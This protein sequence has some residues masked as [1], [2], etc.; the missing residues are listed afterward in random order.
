MRKIKLILGAS[1]LL[2]ASV[3]ANA[4]LIVNGS[5]EDPT[6]VGPYEHRNGNELTGWT[7]FSTYKGT[8]Q[9]D[10]SY[11]A[12]S[13]GSQAVQIEVPGDWISQSF[14]T[15]IGQEYKV[16]FDLSAYPVYGG[17]NLGRATCAPFCVSVLGV[18]AGSA[19]GVFS[20]ISVAYL[21]HALLFDA[22]STTSTVK[23]KNLYDGDG[24]GNYPHLDNVSVE[25]VPA[26]AAIWLFGIGMIGLGFARRRQRSGIPGS[27]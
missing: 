15:V 7:I 9:F 22:D 24:W 5:F 2:L 23:F 20:G 16:S 6:I 27:N 19:S 4:S 25:A 12:V 11:A 1:I 14:A 17:R 13:E 3:Q 8:V 21:T 10:T 18:T 26:P